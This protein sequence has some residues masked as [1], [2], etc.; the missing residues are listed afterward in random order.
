MDEL[1]FWSRDR[2]FGLVIR[3][4]LA[5]KMRKECRNTRGLETGGVIL[6]YY[7]PSH[8]CAIVTDVTLAPADS[9]RTRTAF[10]RGVQG[11]QR[12]LA[13]LW[14][15]KR[16]YYLG[17]WHYHPGAE[18]NPSGVDDRQMVSISDDTWAHCPEPI[19]VIL[20][21]TAAMDCPVR[22]FVY[23]KNAHRRELHLDS[24]VT[25]E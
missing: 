7:T 10:N 13:R 16:H 17:E 18:P 24:D 20:G 12:L 25:T 19:L 15:D 11:L 4:D 14:R 9:K 2:R 6:G 23:P 1:E 21:G 3:E 5:E 8:D 22:A